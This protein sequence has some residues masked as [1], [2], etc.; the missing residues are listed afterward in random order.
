MTFLADEQ[1]TADFGARLAD[2]L[3]P[4]DVVCLHGDL[5]AGKSALAR[6]AIRSLAADPALEVPSPTFTLVQVYDTRIGS[7]WH[8]DLYRLS[9]PEEAIELGWEEALVSGIVLLEWPERL[10]TLLP[11]DHIDVRLDI[12]AGGAGR[13]VTVSVPDTD[14]DL[15]ARFAGFHEAGAASRRA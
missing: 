11:T 8:F 6:A 3:R 12:G 4:G 5:G 7:V 2:V 13:T 1:A 9:D 14:D 10:G 15:G